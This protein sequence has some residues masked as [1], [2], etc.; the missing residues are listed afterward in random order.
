MS[1]LPA[2]NKEFRVARHTDPDTSKEASASVLITQR[3][4]D[5]QICGKQKLPIE[6][7]CDVYELVL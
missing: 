6:P 5:V 3:E 1:T 7:K 4:Q 2:T